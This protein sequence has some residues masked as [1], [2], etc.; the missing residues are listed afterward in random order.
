[1]AVKDRGFASM[2]PLRQREIASA[3]GRMAHRRGSAHQ[4][5]SAEAAAAGRKGALVRSTHMRRAAATDPGAPALP[6][7][8]SSAAVGKGQRLI[9]HAWQ[10]CGRDER[11][12]QC[13]IHSVQGGI[14]VWVGYADEPLAR[15]QVFASLTEARE[16]SQVWRQAVLAKE[17]F[18]EIVP[19]ASALVADPTETETPANV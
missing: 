6:S 11:V 5:T 13:D 7:P 2:D 19:S 3:G 12:L 4:W 17:H 14:E 10:V 18:T 15:S 9:E 8:T 1:M 16:F